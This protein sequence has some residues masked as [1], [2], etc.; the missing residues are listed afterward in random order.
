MLEGPL[1]QH[2][3][4]AERARGGDLPVSRVPAAVLRDH[5]LDSVRRQQFA[6]VGFA[7]GAAGEYVFRVR[8]GERRI[9]GID[10][11][12]DVAMLRLGGEGGDFLS[13]DCEEYTLRLWA[14]GLCRRLDTHHLSPS[15]AGKRLPRGASQA[16]QRRAGLQGCLNGAGGN[17]LR[18]RMRGVDQDIHPIVA[19]V[20]REPFCPAEAPASRRH[21]L[22]A[23]RRCAT[24][25][26]KRHPEVGARREA[27]CELSR[28]GRAAKNEDA[29]RH[30]V[31]Y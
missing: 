3:A 27:R 17:R 24:G 4:D 10:R 18:V 13:A 20:H 16:Q 29:L 30:V 23:R 6:I 7:E 12:Y 26:R 25:E 9:D 28:F 19:Q 31:P 14:Q 11:S 8:N 21:R 2:D 15:I 5:D 1:Q 22:R